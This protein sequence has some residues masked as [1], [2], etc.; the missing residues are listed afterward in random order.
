MIRRLQSSQDAGAAVTFLL[1]GVAG[2]WFGRDYEIGTAARMGPGYVPRLLSVGLLVFGVVVGLRAVTRPGPAI[3][4]VGW[5]TTMLVLAA[6]LSFVFLIAS[7]GLATA[8]FV[9]TVLSALASK[10]TSWKETIALALF[11]AIF[12]VL[13]F[14]YALRQPMSVFGSG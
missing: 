1:T 2:L 8:T 14:I 10:Q 13:V 4:P 12:C 5:R 7:A 11:L 3:E 9:V 6:I